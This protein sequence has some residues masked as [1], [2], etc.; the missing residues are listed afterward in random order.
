MAS[1]MAADGH[2]CQFY[3]ETALVDPADATTICASYDLSNPN[4]VTNLLNATW[5]GGSYATDMKQ[6]TGISQAQFDLFYDSATTDT[7]GYVYYQALS[8]ISTQYSCADAANCTSTELAALQY[9]SLYVTQNP[10]SSWS[11]TYMPVADT[12]A[13]WGNTA[14]YPY[15]NWTE[16]VE[17]PP[18]TAAQ[19]VDWTTLPPSQVQAMMSAS[20]EEYGL[21]TLWNW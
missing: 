17:Y 21:S 2:D 11:A 19:K 13:G 16:P 4:D 8:E 5:Y 10:A 7:F 14:W 18:F 3:F 1:I 12:V 9:G 6:A 15:G 20:Y